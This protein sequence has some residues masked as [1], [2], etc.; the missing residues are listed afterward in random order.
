MAYGGYRNLKVWQRAMEVV[1]DV[2]R[3]TQKLPAFER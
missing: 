3:L 1:E 2:Y